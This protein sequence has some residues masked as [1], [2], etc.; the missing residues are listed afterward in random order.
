MSGSLHCQ[1]IMLE[2]AQRPDGG[3]SKDSPSSTDIE[4]CPLLGSYV[5]AMHTAG[6]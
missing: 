3:L 1:A 4:I 2:A 5:A 6:Q